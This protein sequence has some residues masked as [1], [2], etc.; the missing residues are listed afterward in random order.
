MQPSAEDEDYL[1]AAALAG[2]G[3]YFGVDQAF[4]PFRAVMEEQL[5]EIIADIRAQGTAITGT[6]AKP[7]F[8]SDRLEADTAM[9]QSRFSTVGWYGSLKGYDLNDTTG[10]IQYPANWEASDE[11]PTHSQRNIFT[12]GLAGAEAFTSANLAQFTAIQRGDLEEVPAS[13]GFTASDM[14][15]YIRGNQSHEGVLDTDFRSRPRSLL[16]DMVN[17]APVY[18]G[19][20]DMYYSESNHTG[21]TDYK[22]DKLSRS[23][24]VYVGANDGM[25]HAFNAIT[26][27]EEWA[28]IPQAVFKGGKDEGLSALAHKTFNNDHRYYVDGTPV[29]VDVYIDHDGAN[30]A[31][32]DSDGKQW[33]TV[34]IGTMRGGAAGIFALD[35]T[36]PIPAGGVDFD[37]LLLWELSGSDLIGDFAEIGNIYGDPSV[38]KLDDDR[39][40]VVFGNGYNGSTNKA[41]L[42][43]LD[44]VDGSL[45]SKI[46]VEENNAATNGL[47]QPKVV[48]LDGN[49]TADRIYAGD[50]LGNMW[51][52]EAY[53]SGTDSHWRSVFA[54]GNGPIPLFSGGDPITKVPVLMEHPDGLG[55]P[56]LVVLFGTGKLLET[57]DLTTMVDSGIYGVF[58][59]GVGGL[60]RVNLVE[61]DLITSGD[62]R[63]FDTSSVALSAASESGWYFDLEAGE[64]AVTNPRLYRGVLFLSTMTPSDGDCD[65]GGDSWLLTVDPVSGAAP[66]FAVLDTNDDGIRNG[67]DIGDIGVNLRGVTTTPA[68]LSD[69]LYLPGT[70]KRGNAVEFELGS[71]SSSNTDMLTWEEIFRNW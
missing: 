57:T 28:Y 70:A 4:Y 24:M 10:E 5:A 67:D 30:T 52:F 12:K 62:S 37:E 34:L 39:W 50:L 11:L 49:G 61:R 6:A 65:L 53:L 17:S 44:V 51:A 8:S 16:G 13:S 43:V 38:V 68:I 60:S 18:V 32:D 64:R 41:A 55:S 7:V 69:R 48:D 21:Y 45:I 26:G 36:D 15:E 58:D 42:Y 40:G 2:G 66:D 25:L 29:V 19:A 63:Q 46:A 35:V 27:V 14:I 3:L 9:Y 56:N 59:R 31:E 33:R 54:G 22:T 23:P 1:K 71:P 47:A 20:P